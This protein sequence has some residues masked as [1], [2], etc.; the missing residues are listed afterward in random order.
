M[1]KSV[2]RLTEKTSKTTKTEADSVHKCI[3]CLDYF[4]VGDTVAFLPCKAAFIEKENNVRSSTATKVTI[5]DLDM[6]HF[7]HYEC[8]ATFL[9]DSIRCPVC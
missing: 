4:S 5:G 9:K 2:E 8:L 7:M 1:P 6:D 3:L